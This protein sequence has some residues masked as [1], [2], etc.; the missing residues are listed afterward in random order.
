[1]TL[2]INVLG[3]EYTVSYHDSKDKPIFEKRGIGGYSDDVLREIVICNMQ[4]HPGFE[5]ESY[6]WC[7]LLEHRILRHEIVHA[8]LSESGL[9]DSALQ[10]DMAW[11]KNEEMV[12]WIALQFPKLLQ[13]FKD[14]DCI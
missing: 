8:F 7:K 1:M 4:T 2:K 10:A 3:T 11:A 9:Q 14:A 6:E 12:D 5:D 13:A